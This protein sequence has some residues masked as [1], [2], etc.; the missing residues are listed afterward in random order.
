M[1]GAQA[2]DLRANMEAGFTVSQRIMQD[3]WTLSQRIKL[4]D[5]SDFGGSRDLALTA[6][7]RHWAFAMQAYGSA[8]SIMSNS[9]RALRGVGSA[10]RLDPETISHLN[11]LDPEDLMA[12]LSE[13]GG[14]PA[15]LIKVAQPGAIARLLQGSQLMLVNGLLSNPLTHAII[16]ASN[17]FQ[18][19]ARPAMRMVGSLANG[20]ASCGA[21]GSVCAASIRL[22]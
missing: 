21:H 9:A 19:G 6:L 18:A 12:T 1:A 7:K 17:L 16:G 8:N 11:S 14:R 13:T 2:G 3:A 15:D 20:T 10:F 22:A 4:G 5:Y